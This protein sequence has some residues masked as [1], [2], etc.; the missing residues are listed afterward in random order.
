VPS[1]AHNVVDVLK[2]VLQ[3][4][5][6]QDNRNREQEL[7][8]RIMRLV[9]SNEQRSR[10]AITNEELLRLRTA[11]SRLDQILQSAIDADQQGL[12]NASARLDQLLADIRMGKDVARILKR[13]TRANP[14]E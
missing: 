1:I 11:S 13:R 6:T 8:E 12:Q 14:E 9:R 10:Q 5:D 7:R 4:M 3:G 2:F